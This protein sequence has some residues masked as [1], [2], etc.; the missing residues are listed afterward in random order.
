L[1]DSVGQRTWAI[2]VRVWRSDLLG[3]RV[4]VEGERVA[5]PG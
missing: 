4:A 3:A 2:R 1:E 5:P